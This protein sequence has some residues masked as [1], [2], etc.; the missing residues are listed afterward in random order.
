MIPPT[1]AQVSLA[2]DVLV[3]PNIDDVLRAH[4]VDVIRIAL[5]GVSWTGATDK[6][7]QYG[8]PVTMDDAE[9]QLS[10]RLA[11]R[12]MEMLRDPKTTLD[13]V[14]AIFPRS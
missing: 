3:L 9:A 6:S 4:A 5:L 11:A 7:K 12:L 8:T 13:D 1:A 10:V 2:L 14:R